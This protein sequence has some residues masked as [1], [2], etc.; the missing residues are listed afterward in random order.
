MTRAGRGG[1]RVGAGR[2]RSPVEQVRR[3]RLVLMLT[4]AERKQLKAL[5]RERGVPM[6]TLGHELLA[7]SLSRRRNE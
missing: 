2:P 7:R 4:D 3:N 1:P 5:A 6:G